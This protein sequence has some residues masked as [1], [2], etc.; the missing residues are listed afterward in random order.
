MSLPPHVSVVNVVH[1]LLSLRL[2]HLPLKYVDMHFWCCQK[3]TDR[4]L[5]IETVLLSN[6]WEHTSV[7]SQLFHISITPRYMN[8]C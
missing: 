2:I 1:I 7:W 4:L 3:S 5:F 8:L 6:H